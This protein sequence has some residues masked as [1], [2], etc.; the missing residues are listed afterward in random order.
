MNAKSWLC[1]GEIYLGGSV[2]FTTNGV[3]MNEEHLLVARDDNLVATFLEWFEQLWLVATV[4]T[5][6][7]GS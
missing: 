7:R 5:A 4:V 6:G 2:N 3:R 1:D